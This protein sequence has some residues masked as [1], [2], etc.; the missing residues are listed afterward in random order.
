MD[1]PGVLTTEWMTVDELIHH[2]ELGDLVE[3][4]RPIGRQVAY[5]HWALYIGFFETEHVAVHLS[6]EHGDFG[7]EEKTEM[8]AKMT[9]NGSSAHVR[10]DPILKIANGQLC[11]IN[12]S[13]DSNHPPFPPNVIYERA[14]Y[15][16]GKSGYNLIYNNCE[17][18]VKECRYGSAESHQVTLASSLLGGIVA[19][20]V[21]SSVTVAVVGGICGYAFMKNK[22]KII[23]SIPKLSNLF[24]P[25]N[26]SSP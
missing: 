23:N 10:S 18:F 12:N 4:H 17:H 14:I 8:R 21:C 24:N 16:L 25:S 5:A 22:K 20:A 11:R 7:L 15:R 26:P 9:L 13:L 3:F 2:L 1:R 6:T 19:G